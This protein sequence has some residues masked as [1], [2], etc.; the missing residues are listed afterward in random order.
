LRTG[1]SCLYLCIDTLKELALRHQAI[2]SKSGSAHWWQR[3][4]RRR[5]AASR[6]AGAVLGLHW[7]ANVAPAICL[8][9]VVAGDGRLPFRTL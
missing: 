5:F 9:V 7:A 2:W 3:L 6:R 4:L 8:E 1:Q